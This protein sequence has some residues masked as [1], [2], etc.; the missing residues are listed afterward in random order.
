MKLTIETNISNEEL[1]HELLRE[2]GYC[3]AAYRENLCTTVLSIRDDIEG[4]QVYFTN[5]VISLVANSVA[6]KYEAR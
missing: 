4:E 5:L 6:F 3:G 1:I 2:Q